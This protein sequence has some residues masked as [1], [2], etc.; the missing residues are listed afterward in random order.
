MMARRR[1]G[2][3][4]ARGAW[5]LAGLLTACVA[6]YACDTP[7]YEYTIHN[8]ARDYY[9]IRYFYSGQE[10]AADVQVNDY[11]GGAGQRAGGSANLSFASV[12][13]D[14]L[15]PNQSPSH[16]RA[17]NRHKSERLPFYLVT[18]PRGAE[19][20][21]GHLDLNASRTMLDSPKRGELA[22]QLSEGKQG[23]LVTLLGQSGKE[24]TEARTA[25][26][27]VVAVADERGLD[28]AVMEV[29]R[30][31]PAE[32]W[33]VRQLL[34][35]EDD[36]KDIP[37]PM[38]FGAFG[39]GYVVPP[40]VGK[41]ITVRNLS[42]LVAFIN[43]PCAC[44]IKAANPGTDLL[45]DWNWDAHLAGWAGGTES[46]PQFVIFDVEE[47]EEPD[48]EPVVQM[49]LLSDTEG[50]TPTEGT[51]ST[52]PAPTTATS[53]QR[54]PVRVPPASA[55]PPA[56]A[57]TTEPRS[58]EAGAQS[59][60][61]SSPAHEESAQPSQ[62][63]TTNTQSEGLKPVSETAPAE[64][65][66]PSEDAAQN[67]DARVP[68]L[69]TAEV[70]PNPAEEFEREQGRSL[71]SSLSVGLGVTIGTVALLALAGGVFLVRRARES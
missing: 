19:V 56:P 57:R 45:T 66:Q 30:S 49:P 55:T 1:G 64:L 69:P 20:F 29:S 11:L 54:E 36:L 3:A 34:S 18:S 12:D 67:E 32:Q 65:G 13:V 4:C 71:T 24:N 31:D 38:V 40:Y 8:W 16:Q 42:D 7:V 68:D 41:G 59:E 35:I 51:P 14:S 48:G 9:Q 53:A 23:V 62:V 5:L 10:D 50:A 46:Q 47:E 60:S 61:A 58:A 28:V 52:E 63:P 2:V 25:V 17:W 26:R 22:E 33:F 15:D 21:V 70:P 39:R 27:D 44:E 37:R 6:V 43:G